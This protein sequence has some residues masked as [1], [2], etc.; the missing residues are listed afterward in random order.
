MNNLIEYYTVLRK[1][2]E[3]VYGDNDKDYVQQA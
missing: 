2:L 1:T 3:M